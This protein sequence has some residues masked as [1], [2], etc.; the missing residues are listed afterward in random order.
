[1]NAALQN[2]LIEKAYAL[3]ELPDCAQ[4]HFTFIVNRNKIISLGWN[5]AYRTHPIAKKFNC[6]FST[7]HSELAAIKNFHGTLDEICRFKLI[8]IRIRRDNNVGI[9]KPCDS[10]MMMLAAFDF[11][12]VWYTNNDGGFDRL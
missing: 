5:Q 6:R 9:S 4:K 8:N 11:N 7:I 1:M 10:C 12:E 2:K 3:K